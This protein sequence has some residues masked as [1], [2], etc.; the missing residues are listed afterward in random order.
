MS[1]EN[2]NDHQN[3]IPPLRDMGLDPLA[4][5][6]RNVQKIE[7]QR[8]ALLQAYIRMSEKS[9]SLFCRG[10]RIA[11]Q[12][13]PM[14]FDQVA[15]QYQRTC[16]DDMTP[17]IEALRD[18]KMPPKRRFWIERT[19]K[20]SKDAD[21]AVI[22]AWLLA[23]PRRPFYGQ[24]GAAD[25]EQ[26]AIVRDR[27]SALLVFNPWLND[28]IELVAYEIRSKTTRPDGS[29]LA[30]FTIKS[31]D[32]AGAHGGTPD[33]LILNELSHIKKWEFAENL[34]DNADGVAQGVV[35]IATNAGFKNSKP[36]KWRENALK[37]KEWTLHVLARPAPWHDEKTIEDAKKRNDASRFR[38]L[39][40]GEWVNA[41]SSAL[42]EDEIDSVFKLEG[43]VEP[44]RGDWVYFGGLDLGI[45][46]DHAAF[47]ILGV[48]GKLRKIKL[49]RF[50]RWIPPKGGKI[51]LI[52]VRD[53]IDRLA[54]HYRLYNLFY[55]PY[56]AELM[57]QE[58][59]QRGHR[60]T[61]MTFA[62][63]TN[64]TKMATAFMQAVKSGDFLCYDE[65]GIVRGD[66][67]KFVIVDKGGTF[68]LDAVS[69]EA[70][71]AD[72]GTAIVITLPVALEMLEVSNPLLA[73]DD[74]IVYEDEPDLTIEEIKNLPADLAAIY[75]R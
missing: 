47:T 72:V 35:L 64:L 61:E 71:H 43:P 55:D 50:L 41:I 8:D 12:F 25:R 39:W 32:V 36:W 30:Y 13:G 14:L 17:S 46:H 48:S 16:F 65:D 52:K 40:W 2:A 7:K 63:S 10:L 5:R 70:G 51:D 67:G 9:F 26:A 58:L 11:S 29:A 33:L 24:I 15:A 66:F 23:F 20:A 42:T 75:G 18:G 60:S 44:E 1:S 31:A 68:R 4:I 74:V 62:S 56:Q 69:D 45:S 28:R 49:C 6:M 57:V 54:R 3:E 21:L 37:S 27:L 19:K 59:R 53:D 34:L 73:P 22:V 38:R